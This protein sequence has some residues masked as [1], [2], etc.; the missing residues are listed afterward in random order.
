MTLRHRALL[1]GVVF[2]V[3]AAAGALVAVPTSDAAPPWFCSS[4][5]NSPMF[6]GSG[7]DCTAATANLSSQANTYV[8][9][10]CYPDGT[11]S[12]Q[13]IVTTGC[14]GSNPV[15]IDGYMRYRCK[16]LF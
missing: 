6:W 3:A 5:I 16:A 1:L 14:H 2:V 7:V 4:Y 15:M 11:C 10:D 13:L 12:R 8:D 9:Q